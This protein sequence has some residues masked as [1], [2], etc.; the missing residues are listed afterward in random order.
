VGNFFTRP[1]R[2]SETPRSKLFSILAFGSFIFLFLFL[3]KPFGMFQLESGEQLFISLGFGMITTFVLIVF[4]YLIEPVVIKSN[5]TMGKNII[6]D[7]IIASGIGGANY[8]YICI[9]F[10]VSFNI[11]YLL[12]SIWTAIL[13]G[14]IPVTISYFISYNRLYKHALKEAEVPEDIITWEDEVII[15][16]GYPRNDFRANPKHIAYLCSNDNYVTIVTIRDNIQNKVTIRGTL[17]EAEKELGK[18]SRFIRCHKC[19]I[20]NL[21]FAE[22]VTGN[23]QNMKIFLSPSGIEVPVARSRA[24]EVNRLTAKKSR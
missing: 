14:S 16:A 21:D 23:N 8:L 10:N 12:Y 24:E 19:Y 13:V 3:F 15:T 7:V 4:K 5:W 11:L 2:D 6:W 9:I 18:N 20:I 22:R 1:Y 17:K